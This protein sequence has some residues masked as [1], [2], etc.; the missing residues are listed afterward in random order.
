[1]NKLYEMDSRMLCGCQFHLRH[2]I[3]SHILYVVREKP[4][5]CDLLKVL[6]QSPFSLDSFLS[7]WTSLDSVMTFTILKN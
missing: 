4:M 3:Q 2:L 1:M 7:G 6:R 5:L